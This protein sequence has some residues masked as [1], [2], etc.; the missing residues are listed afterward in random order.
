MTN[1]PS[2]APAE[3]PYWSLFL[4]GHFGGASAGSRRL[5]V[6]IYTSLAARGGS[7]VGRIRSAAG[8]NARRREESDAF[9]SGTNVN[10]AV[11][12]APTEPLGREGVTAVGR[13][14]SSESMR[15]IDSFLDSSPNGRKTLSC[16]P[17][18]FHHG[19]LTLLVGAMLAAPWLGTVLPGGKL[20]LIP[21][22]AL[23]VGWI[24]FAFRRYLAQL[25]EL[26][27]RI[28]YEAIAFSFGMTLLLG[29]TAASASSVTH[30]TVHPG[31]IVMA[32]PLRGLGLVLAARKYR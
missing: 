32:E 18:D 14:R 25:D 9:L 10:E 28:Q 3:W 23:A 5:N 4:F 17:R 31:W 26:S 22:T 27:L 29:V 30:L 20:F 24:L 19:L 13:C 12:P 11:D 2:E 8:F 16:D 7:R 15:R 1:T 6:E 21:G